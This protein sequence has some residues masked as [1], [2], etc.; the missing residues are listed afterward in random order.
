MKARIIILE[1]GQSEE[2]NIRTRRTREASHEETALPALHLSGATILA[3]GGVATF[4]FSSRETVLF[5][6]IWLRAR[7]DFLLRGRKRGER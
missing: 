2:S 4:G 6:S 7:V 3:R 5:S 1:Q